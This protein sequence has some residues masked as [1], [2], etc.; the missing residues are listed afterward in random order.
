MNDVVFAFL[1]TL[2]AGLFTAIGGVIALFAKRENI[3]FLA[4]CLS[5]SAGVMIY[6]SFVEILDKAKESLQYVYGDEKGFFIATIAFFGG[7]L[8]VALIDKL[9]P[10]EDETIQSL[11]PKSDNYALVGKDMKALRRMGLMSA[12]AIAIHNFPEGL[13]TFM[14]TLQ[15]PTVGVAIAFAIAIHNIPEGIAVAIPIY[16]ATGSKKKALLISTASGLTEPLG[17]LVAYLFL[18]N[19]FNDVA[20][21]IVFAAV[22]GIMIHISFNQLLPTAQ[23]YGNHRSVMKGLFAGMFVMALSLVI[24]G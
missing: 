8:I 6:I 20:F 7:I 5:F 12:I 11:T 10:H 24:L 13:V 1:I 4:I 23:K 19:F 22:G 2:I 17:A 16:Y 15:D 14:A 3:N 18:I 21:G 9:I